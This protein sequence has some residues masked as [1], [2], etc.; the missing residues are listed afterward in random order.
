VSSPNLS[1]SSKR[2]RSQKKDRGPRRKKKRSILELLI[3]NTESVD[4][5]GDSD[6]E[7]ANESSDLSL[8]LSPPRFNLAELEE[9]LEEDHWWPGSG[10]YDPNIQQET[11]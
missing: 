6:G 10:T 7:K 5:T 4:L 1:L 9:A 11:V 3:T 8:S 2:K